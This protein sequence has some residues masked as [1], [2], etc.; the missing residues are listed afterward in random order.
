TENPVEINA[1]MES[2]AVGFIP[3]SYSPDK[4]FRAIDHI[5]N[6]K[7]YIPDEYKQPIQVYKK[8]LQTL[9]S[10]Y[11]IGSRQ[12]EVLHC[13]HQGLSNK[14]IGEQLFISEA[15]VKSHISSLFQAFQAKNRVECLASA[16]K[17]GLISTS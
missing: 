4:V 17:L 3:K 12:I 10:Q 13:M 11:K 2:G 8:Q 16:S 5:M 14:N 7:C 1:A 9:A 6:G 15:T